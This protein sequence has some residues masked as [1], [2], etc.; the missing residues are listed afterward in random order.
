MLV[1]HLLFSNTVKFFMSSNDE[2]EKV[3]ENREIN[4]RNIFLTIFWPKSTHKSTTFN[5]SCSLGINMQMNNYLSTITSTVGS[6]LLEWWRFTIIHHKENSK[7]IFL[8][9]KKFYNFTGKTLVENLCVCK[10]LKTFHCWVNN[11]VV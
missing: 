11:I 9:S 1:F 4:R 5:S 7:E 8:I 10:K 6:V 2:Q 3:R